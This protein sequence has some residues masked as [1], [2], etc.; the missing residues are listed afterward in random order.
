VKVSLVEKEDMNTIGNTSSD[1]DGI[2]KKKVPGV[3]DASDSMKVFSKTATLLIP[4]DSKTCYSSSYAK[5]KGLF[6]SNA[7]RVT[8]TIMLK[9]HIYMS[10][11]HTFFPDLRPLKLGCRL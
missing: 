2:S 8:C 3:Q 1:S 10:I 11:S 6:H 5:L 4:L 7:V 9:V